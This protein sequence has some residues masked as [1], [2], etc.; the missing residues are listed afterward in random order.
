[1]L[2]CMCW[3]VCVLLVVCICVLRAVVSTL[4]NIVSC[5]FVCV[6]ACARVRVAS[7]CVCVCVCNGLWFPRSATN[8]R[9]GLYVL[10]CACVR[11]MC[12]L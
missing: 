5:Q 8:S 4:C 11:G 7:V 10:G 9:V 2:V 12:A 3:C 1:M 6:C